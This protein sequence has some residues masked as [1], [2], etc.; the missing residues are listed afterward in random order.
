MQTQRWN[1]LGHFFGKLFGLMDQ[2]E[3]RKQPPPLL[4]SNRR[5][6]N[7]PGR[8]PVCVKSYDIIERGWFSIGPSRRI[9][10]DVYWLNDHRPKITVG[11]RGCGR[12]NSH[13]PTLGA[14]RGMRR[15][16][17]FKFR[18]GRGLGCNMARFV[19]RLSG[20]AVEGYSPGNSPVMIPS[21]P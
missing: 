2:V 12:A 5:D 18:Q 13:I 1:F 15:R 4:L 8:A 11:L 10:A 6:S 20:G 3:R 21:L 14:V 17:Y 19:D 9:G 16:L 7:H